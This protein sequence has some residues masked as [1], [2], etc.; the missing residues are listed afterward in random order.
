MP[1]PWERSYPEGV[2]WNAPIPISTLTAEL[3]AS[4]ERFASVPRAGS[5]RWA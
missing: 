5:G 1:Q 3:D 4:I 2:D